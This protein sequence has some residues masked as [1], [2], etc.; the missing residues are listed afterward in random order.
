MDWDPHQ[1]M[2]SCLFEL[3]HGGLQLQLYQA[4]NVHNAMLTST[5]KSQLWVVRLHKIQNLLLRTP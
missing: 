5:S 3:M 2:E 1:C 4:Y